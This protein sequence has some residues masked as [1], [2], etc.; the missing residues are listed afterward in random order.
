MSS[1]F[2][3]WAS[4]EDA[5]PHARN[6]EQEDKQRSSDAADPSFAAPDEPTDELREALADARRRLQYFEGFAPWI[7]E[8]MSTVVE[9][10]AEVAG[11][12]EREQ[13]RISSEIERQ[14]AEMERLV[15]ECHR[16][17][18][19]AKTI[20]ED[21]NASAEGVINEANAQASRLLVEAQH[22]ADSLVNR[23]RDEAAAI[24]NRAMGDLTALEAAHPLEVPASPATWGPLDDQPE[25]H[26]VHAEW[27]SPA[28]EASESEG[29]S[30]QPVS[31]EFNE[32]GPSQ[33]P[34]DEPAGDAIW[35]GTAV[36]E[37]EPA[38]QASSEAEGGE[39]LG[40]TARDQVTSGSVV[41]DE[42]LAEPAE[43]GPFQWLRSALVGRDTSQ[44]NGGA[45]QSAESPFENGTPFPPLAP[46]TAPEGSDPGADETFITR[47]TIHPAYTHHERDM[48]QRRIG[49]LTGVEGVAFGRV[50]EDFFELL[51]TH[52][53]F[54][55]VLGS[56][57]VAAGENMRLIA[58]HDESLEVEI[59]SLD[60][61][62]T[63]ADAA[64]I[65]RASDA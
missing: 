4:S 8:Q 6:G 13:Q 65:S 39:S 29:S 58:Q 9:R 41:Q 7:E 52:Q 31:P 49:G 21:A 50:T 47:L 51:V 61:I 23:M 48:V 34:V 54:T 59:T 12:S 11:E 60:W 25:S 10:A 36:A 37:S 19:E 46:D 2:S 20:V 32:E 45:E 40:D 14:R 56:L 22:N 33:A 53:L 18:E 24:V 26:E 38:A 1:T 44:R 35:M 3:N 28:I 16:L 43:S 62:H 30:P 64:E 63:G 15:E 55:S 17:R 27:V 5:R 57:L 42:A